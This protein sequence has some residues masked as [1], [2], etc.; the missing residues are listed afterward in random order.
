MTT[1]ITVISDTH[2]Q[3]W[4]DIHPTIK[5]EIM[6]SDISIHCGDIIKQSVVD[7]FLEAAQK[8]IL[9][10]G[11]SDPVD[12]RKSLP[13]VQSIQVED[14]LI[15]ITHPAWGGPE[16]PP[17]ELF[18]DFNVKPDLIL[19]GHTH[20]PLQETIDGT[21]FVNPGQGYASFMVDGTLASITINGTEI[22][23]EIRT[24]QNT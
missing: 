16:F 15:G 13:Y 22:K 10:H 24:I 8:A 23:S 21:L 12:L 11:N 14:V 19:F 3:R 17:S 4:E 5:E 2:C 20:Q 7:G 6:L 18:K 9:V 1:T